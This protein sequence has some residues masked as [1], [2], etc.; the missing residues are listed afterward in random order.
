MFRDTFLESNK[1]VN[2]LRVPEISQN[3][4]AL[5]AF[6]LTEGKYKGSSHQPCSKITKRCI[7]FSPWSLNCGFIDVYN[8][9]IREREVCGNVTLL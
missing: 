7:I 3:V 4:W 6:L 9:F 2:I 1:G 5:Y 8:G